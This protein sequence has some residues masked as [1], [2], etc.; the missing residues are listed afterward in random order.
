MSKE[1]IVKSSKKTLSER[2]EYSLFGDIQVYIKDPLTSKVDM[3]M[4]IKKLEDSIPRD[5]TY[6]VELIIVGQFDDLN[7]RG[8]KAAFLDGAIYVTNDQN[9]VDDIF[10][11]IV[12]EISHSVEKTHGSIL[13]S[14]GLVVQE[15]LGKKQRLVD[16]LTADGLLVPPDISDEVEYSKEFDEFLHFELGFEKASNYTNGLFIDS[17][18]SVSISEYFATGFESYYVEQETQALKKISPALYEK[19]ET[20]T[21]YVTEDY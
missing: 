7:K 14:D 20:L 18:A 16:L 17:Y 6:G 10:D 11:D 5:F 3:S 2:R 15:Y 4:V 21:N 12:H 9:D 19:I 8:V 1:Y 13:F